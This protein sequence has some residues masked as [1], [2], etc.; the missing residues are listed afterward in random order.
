MYLV[1]PLYVFPLLLGHSIPPNDLQ[2]LRL[3]YDH[4]SPHKLLKPFEV[5]SKDVLMILTMATPSSS[6][7]FYPDKKKYYDSMGRIGKKC[8]HS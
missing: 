3:Y 5:L 6:F 7:Q 2:H 4:S 8:R 1:A